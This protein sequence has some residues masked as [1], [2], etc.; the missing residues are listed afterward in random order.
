MNPCPISTATRSATRSQRLR[1]P[2]SVL[3][4]RTVDGASPIAYGYG[5]TLPVYFSDGPV[6]GLSNTAGGRSGRG[7]GPG[8][9]R[10]RSTGRG[11]PDEID[12][13]QNRPAVEIPEE[14]RA[15]P[16]EAT[17]LTDEQRRNGIYV[18]PPQ[19]RPRVVM[20]FADARDLAISGLVENGSDIAQRPAVVDVPVGNGHVV[21]FS[22]NPVWRGETRG[23]YFLVLN[24]ILNFGSLDAGRK[25]DAK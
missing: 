4:A 9:E 13:P 11:M 2:G 3:R 17:P 21:L 16:W 8:S 7:G 12:Q 20:R 15:E 19:Y 24:A 25:L 18:I 5:D 14:P 10:E 1:A 22:N 23:S 6:F